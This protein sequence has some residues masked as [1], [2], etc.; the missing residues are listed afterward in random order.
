[1]ESS[2]RFCKRDMSCFRRHVTHEQTKNISKPVNLCS[3]HCRRQTSLAGWQNAT[4][5]SSTTNTFIRISTRS[6]EID[7]QGQK[8]KKGLAEKTSKGSSKDNEKNMSTWEQHRLTGW[9]EHVHCF[10]SGCC[11]CGAFM[12]DTHLTKSCSWLLTRHETTVAPV[13]RAKEKK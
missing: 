8:E 11:G 3:T 5:T 10:G 7:K 4:A 2:I 6:S 9:A 12:G 1:M 13:I